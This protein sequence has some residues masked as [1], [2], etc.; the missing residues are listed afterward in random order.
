MDR[1]PTIVELADAIEKFQSRIESF[2]ARYEYE[3]SCDDAVAEA[4]LLGGCTTSGSFHVALKGKKRYK[5]WNS[6][7]ISQSGSETRTQHN[8]AYDGV[9][10]RSRIGK[11]KIRIQPGKPSSSGDAISS[12]ICW[13]NTD[14]D[15]EQIESDPEHAVFFPSILRTGSWAISEERVAHIDRP[16]VLAVNGGREVCAWFDMTLGPN[17]VRLEIDNPWHGIEKQTRVLSDF[18][19]F[20]DNVSLPRHITQ[21]SVVFA[22]ETEQRIGVR[23][24]TVKVS[25]YSVNDIDDA[26]F[27]VAVAEGD[28]VLR[29]A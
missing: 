4:G 15:W 11:T 26:L 25:E 5:K 10:T 27:S 12:S 28:R 3:L 23:T 24:V 16:V 13:P 2:S 14:W 1:L 8:E 19:S 29:V 21:E 18:Q 7:G 17:V 6:R 22:P 9:E 20:D